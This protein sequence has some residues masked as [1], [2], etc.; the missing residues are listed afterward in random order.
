MSTLTLSPTRAF[1]WTALSLVLFVGALIAT[2]PIVAIVDRLTDVPHV[3][4]AAARPLV[5][6]GLSVTGV[7]FAARLAFG[8]WIPISR[9]ALAIA[10]TGIALSAIVDVVLHQWTITRFGSFASDFVGW[11]A[12]LFALLV[13]LAVASFGAMVAPRPVIG[14][15]LSA[16]LLGAVAVVFVVSLNA[17]GLSDGIADE[18]WG[19]AIWV[20]LSALYALGSA[21]FAIRRAL[22]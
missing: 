21:G 1:M 15:P 3:T 5:W 2:Q 22:S 8:A 9:L 20:G 7:L 16:V 17:A 18:S 13:G 6:G 10:A 19:L 14:W 11:T 4:R 12:G